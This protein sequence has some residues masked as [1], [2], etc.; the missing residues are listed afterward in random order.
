ML[1]VDQ[2]FVDRARVLGRLANAVLG[3]LVENDPLY[4][5]FRGFEYLRHMPSDGLPFAVG[6]G[7]KQDMVDLGGSRLDVFDCLA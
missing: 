5:F 3:D 4:G 2:V 7:R 6:V 1:R